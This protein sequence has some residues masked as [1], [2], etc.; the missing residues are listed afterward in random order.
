MLVSFDSCKLVDAQN[1]GKPY[2]QHMS[3]LPMKIG[4][5]EYLVVPMIPKVVSFDILF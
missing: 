3:H 5:R 2:H 4:L 1:V